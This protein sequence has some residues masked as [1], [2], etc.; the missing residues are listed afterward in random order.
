MIF[1]VLMLAI[2]Q[3]PLPPSAATCLADH[4]PHTGADV[5]Y[6]QGVATITDIE[7]FEHARGY[8]REH[9]WGRP[10]TWKR[11]KHAGE[12]VAFAVGTGIYYLSSGE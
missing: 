12:L 2:L 5:C 7:A 10:D 4:P 6:A 8:H 3:T 1:T 9:H 11:V